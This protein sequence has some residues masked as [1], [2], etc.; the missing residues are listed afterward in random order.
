MHPFKT[1][2]ALIALPSVV[3]PIIAVLVLQMFNWKTAQNIAQPYLGISIIA[4]F[5]WVPTVFVIAFRYPKQP[6]FKKDIPAIITILL[7]VTGVSAVIYMMLTLFIST[8][9][10]GF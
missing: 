7:C 9:Y 4:P 1:A 2:V 6:A 5:I 3:I 10:S 8:M